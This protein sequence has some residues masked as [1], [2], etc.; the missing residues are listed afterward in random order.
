MLATSP[1][2]FYC[3]GQFVAAESAMRLQIR[4]RL[5]KVI[6]SLLIVSRVTLRLTDL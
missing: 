6:L 3:S 2:T 4:Q 1:R 5:R